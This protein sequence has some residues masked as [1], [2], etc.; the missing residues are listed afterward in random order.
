MFI[1]YINLFVWFS[2]KDEAWLDEKAYYF[3]RTKE[4]NQKDDYSSTIKLLQTPSGYWS[5]NPDNIVIIRD[6]E[7]ILGSKKTLE[8]YEG[9]E[10]KK[11]T[12]WLMEEYMLNMDLHEIQG[13]EVIINIY[14]IY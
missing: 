9:H 11:K 7:R 6:Q 14:I 5:S 3:V 13:K 12:N 4:I 1:N 8:F 10:E 2:E